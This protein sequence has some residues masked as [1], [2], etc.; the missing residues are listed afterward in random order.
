MQ[1]FFKRLRRAF[2]SEEPRYYY[3]GEYGERYGRP[4]FHVLLFNFS[5]DDKKVI[6][7]SGDKILYE[8][9]TLTKLWGNGFCS[10]GSVTPESAAYVARYVLKKQ[11]THDTSDGRQP[12]FTRMSRNP[13]IGAGWIDRFRT[14]VYP[15][16]SVI[17]D[18]KQYPIPRYYD[19]RIEKVDPSL[20]ENSKDVRAIAAQRR[21]ENIRRRTGRSPLYNLA[22]R[23][24]I[25]K[26]KLKQ[27]QRPLD[28]KLGG[29]K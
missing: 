24:V 4:H 28:E 21:I 2:P 18:G 20:V 23:E 10:I 3:C 1:L 5:F 7:G 26:Q 12:E 17:H 8:S 29:S 9:E 11:V 6:S 16:N 25:L 22:N 19:S 27:Y 14:D 15:S 13:G